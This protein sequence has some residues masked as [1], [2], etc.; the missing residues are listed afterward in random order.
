MSGHSRTYTYDTA[1]RVTGTTVTMG[2]ASYVTSHTYDAATGTLT[3]MTYPTASG[4]SHGLTVEYRYNPRGYLT[5]E[6]NA[7]SKYVYREVTAQDAFGSITA[8]RIN[9]NGLLG[10]YEYSS[11]TGQMTSTRAGYDHYLTYDSYDSFGNLQSV[12]NHADLFSASTTQ[13]TYQYDSLH[14]LTRSTVAFDGQSLSIDYGYDAAGNLKKKTDYSTTSASAYTYAPGSNKLQSVALKGGG[15]A[16]FGYDNK[17]NQTH[18]NGQLEVSYNVFSKPALINR[19]GASNTFSYDASL[20][21]YRQVS[22]ATTGGETVTT[23]TTYIGKHFEIKHS[24]GETTFEHYIS[25]VAIVTLGSSKKIAFTHRDRLGSAVTLTDEAN[26]AVSR[27]Y[28]DPFGKPRSG[29]WS[30]TSPATL[31]NNVFELRKDLVRGFTDHEHLDQAEL[32]HMNG[33]VYDY[34]VGQFLSVDPFVH[35]GSQGINPYSYIM[36]NPLSGTDP[37]GYEPETKQKRGKLETIVDNDRYHNGPGTDSRGDNTPATA[38]NGAFDAASAQRQSQ[39]RSGSAPQ[40]VGSQSQLA[41]SSNQQGRTPNFGDFAAGLNEIWSNASEYIPEIF[42]LASEDMSNNLGGIVSS[43]TIATMSGGEAIGE[44][45]VAM[46]Q[47]NVSGLAEAG[48]SFAAGKFKPL[49]NTIEAASDLPVIRQGTS[50]WKQAVNELSSMGK[51]KLNFR[52]E[53]ATDAKQLLLE[54]RGN[55]NRYKNYT[56]TSYSKGYEAHNVQNARELGAGN[57]LQ[58]LKWKDAKS[59]GHIFYNRAN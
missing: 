51:A 26:R 38:R 41:Q 52:T 39:N 16:T 30:S 44:G 18:R 42:G 31:G 2:S 12:T 27:R 22:T 25:D 49:K 15:S 10:T 5:H 19:N 43:D 36:N 58:H 13:D 37:T 47:G 17:G 45:I 7:A 32:I 1:A 59:G 56:N 20:A 50:E 4:H 55:M 57:N 21:R 6:Q 53:T 46:S 14:R 35:G 23:T 3:S 24:G 11:K 29:D 54:G 9:N 40:D 28:F 34:N 8:A 33:R 48:A